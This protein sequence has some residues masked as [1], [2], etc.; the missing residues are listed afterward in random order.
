VAA[1]VPLTA[2]F[3][4]ASL[5]KGT[6]K[7]YAQAFINLKYFVQ[8]HVGGIW[9]PTPVST[10]AMY[11]SHLLSGGKAVSSVLSILSAIAFFHN[12]CSVDDPSSHFIIKRIMTGASKL[13]KTVD[14]RAPVTLPVLH[15][16]VQA[17]KHVTT[18]AY[19]RAMLKAMYLC[20]FHA[21]LRVGEVTLSPNVVLFQQ[22]QFTPQGFSIT[23]SKFKHHKGPP[24]VV[25]VPSSQ[26]PMCPRAAL[27]KF[28]AARGAAPGPLFMFQ[29][30]VTIS[31]RFFSSYL[32]L[33]L[34]WC[35]LPNSNIK[36]HSFRIGAATYAASKG[37]TACQIK[38]MGRWNSNA[39]E[40]YIRID[41]FA[42]F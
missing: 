27:H 38:Q 26:S 41:S 33:S 32:N 12:M 19:H 28:I 22:V 25:H 9:F 37:Y 15:K 10:L 24:V 3:I 11:I 13:A 29:D 40:K 16:L 8:Q 42:T 1:L 36:P 23:F 21:F 17:C 30:D 2:K 14:G 39:F 34:A 31:A 4:T 7:V 5:A 20:M 6:R 35:N 18:S